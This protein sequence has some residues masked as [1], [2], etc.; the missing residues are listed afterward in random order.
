MVAGAKR[1]PSSLVQLTMQIG[2][3]GLDAGIVQGA[4]HLECR[5]RAE[6]A[7]E[8]AA[9]RL[10]I[11]MRAQAHRRFCHVAALAQREHRAERIDMHLE[12]RGFACFAK[13]VAHLL[14][15]GAERQPPHAALRRGAEF[16]GLVDGVPQP[17][18]ID[19]Q[20]GCDFGHAD[21]RNNRRG[22]ALSMTRLHRRVNNALGL[23]KLAASSATRSTATVSGEAS[24]LAENVSGGICR[25]VDSNCSRPSAISLSTIAVGITA[26]P[27]PSTAI[28]FTVASDVLACRRTGGRSGRLNSER[29]IS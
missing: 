20:V 24:Q 13:P 23:R 16:R 18:G 28:C 19:L 10:G 22:T 27:R 4:H 29:T 25:S 12:A 21:F 2:S 7:V 17:C 26:M 9:G 1:E 3:L 11:E 6:H 5:Q 8:L 14:V 15:L